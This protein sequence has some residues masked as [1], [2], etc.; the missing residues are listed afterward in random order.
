MYCSVMPEFSCSV[1]RNAQ[2]P[3]RNRPQVIIV[4][5][6]RSKLLVQLSS[7]HSYSSLGF[8][9]HRAFYLWAFIAIS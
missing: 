4:E 2:I 9:V 8:I 5:T 1:K 6:P 3:A 7:R